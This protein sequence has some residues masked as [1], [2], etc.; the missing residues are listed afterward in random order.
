MEL[1][2]MLHILWRRR[3]LVGVGVLLAVA[4]GILAGSHVQATTNGGS[5][6]SL[7]MV[8]DTV[9]SQLV[10]AA[11]NGSATLPTRALLLAE[12]MATD[13]ATRAIGRRGHVARGQLTVLGPSSRK[14]PPVDTPLV[15]QV[16]LLASSAST[17]YVVSVF[18]DQV[19]PII[20]I[21]AQAA[22]GARSATL[23]RAAGTTLRSQLLLEDGHRSDGFVLDTVAPV[24]TKHVVTHSHRRLMMLA[25]AVGTFGFWCVCIVLGVAL[26]RRARSVT[27]RPV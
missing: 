14:I 5:V 11:P 3:I 25:G 8:L 12:T 22:D 27:P 24:R 23:A 4:V 15:S 10:A 21:E 13:R 17:P 26:H 2:V 1:L 7:R 9:D 18:A 16:Y 6:S 19:T 20:T